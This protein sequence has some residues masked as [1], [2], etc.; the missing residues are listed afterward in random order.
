MIP[1]LLE[2]IITLSIYYFIFFVCILLMAMLCSE[3]LLLSIFIYLS[4]VGLIIIITYYMF[5]TDKRFNLGFDIEI[6]N[7]DTEKK[8]KDKKK[9][10]KEDTEL[11][12][13]LE[14]NLENANKEVQKWL[15]INND[16]ATIF[17][18]DIRMF[19][20]NFQIVN[21]A[22][23][24]R[25]YLE[26]NKFYENDDSVSTIGAYSTWWSDNLDKDN[27]YYDIVNKDY[28]PYIY[29]KILPKYQK[30]I[31]KWY[32][33]D[34]EDPSDKKVIE[35]FKYF[36]KINDINEIKKNYE[37]DSIYKNDWYI[38]YEDL[39]K[40]NIKYSE[41]NR[42]NKNRF[43][44]IWAIIDTNYL[45][46]LLIE[47]SATLEK[48]E[49]LN[50]IGDEY[51]ASNLELDSLNIPN[52]TMVVPDTNNDDVTLYP[53]EDLTNPPSDSYWPFYRISSQY[54]S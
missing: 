31:Y 34:E 11:D 15:K 26:K 18:L 42:E 36:N 4:I 40:N 2:Y 39:T 7:K 8:A 41:D 51:L 35:W 49:E 46:K 48:I 45:F 53:R 30:I 1:I 5:F 22:S 27:Y 19:K 3:P 16:A 12:T 20:N 23:Y 47:N 10:T 6:T 28:K 9:D 32:N 44:W 54:L 21:N 17:L 24:L 29:V 14:T 37:N 13:E 52:F 38:D 50:I 43:S 25:N 33:K